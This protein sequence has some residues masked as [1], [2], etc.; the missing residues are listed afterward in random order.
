MI[1]LFHRVDGPDGAPPLV[2]GNSL[3]CSLA[4]WEPQVP[5]LAGAFRVVR[6]DQRGHG[7]SP[8][9]PG[10]YSLDDL[11]KDL[12]ALLDELG[13]GRALLCGSSMG[14][15]VG[16]WLALEAPERVDRLVLC[17]TSAR[18]GS[19]E[20]WID[21]ARRVREGGVGAVADGVLQRWFTPGFARERP[22]VVERY[23]RMLLSTPAEGYAGCCEALAGADLRE[24]L[25]AI[26]A[27]ALVV[28]GSDDPSSAVAKGR[29]IA[30]AIP[31][32]RHT[33]IGPAAH[34]ANVER[35]EAFTHAITAH[36]D[37]GRP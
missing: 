8:V 16:M 1:E 7:R 3:G 34:L 17:C 9:P 29:E 24:R 21:R 20:S 23:E 6:Y 5:S 31:G 15:M 22:E 35:P 32:A 10:P 25:G 36:L 11:G 26:A 30:D 18:F 14:G 13:I 37:G 2:L 27:P 4:M 33:V 12:L 19:R 28:S